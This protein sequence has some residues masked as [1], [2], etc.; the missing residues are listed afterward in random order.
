MSFRTHFFFHRPYRDR[1]DL[2]KTDLWHSY[3]AD[4]A[5]AMS[6]IGEKTIGD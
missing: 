3:F 1:S 4:A 6:K 2:T 5:A